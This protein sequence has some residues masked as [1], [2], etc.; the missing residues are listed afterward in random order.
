MPAT[1]STL[2]FSLYLAPEGAEITEIC[3]ADNLVYTNLE[4][5]QIVTATG[6]YT[7]PEFPLGGF[8]TYAW[9]ETLISDKGNV[10]HEGACGIT[11]ELT[12]VEVPD[13]TTLA[14]PL[15]TVVDPIFDT[16]VVN[17]S[18]PDNT[19]LEFELY[20]KP[21]APEAGD[22]KYDADGNVTDVAW[23]QEEV[24]AQSDEAVC[25]VSNLVATTSRIAVTAGSNDYVE[26]VS[27]DVNVSETGTYWWVERLIVE[28]PSGD[29]VVLTGECGL[30][31]ETTEVSDPVVTSNA[32]GSVELGEEAH[33]VATVIGPI[34]GENSGVRAELT[35]EAFEAVEAVESTDATDSTEPAEVCAVDNR[36][37]NLDE[38]IIVT[39]A[40][41]YASSSV[42]FPKTGTYYWVETLAYVNIATDE[43]T[44]V[45]VG[46][47]GL[48]EETTIVTAVPVV[49]GT[50]AFT[51][52][53]SIATLLVSGSVALLI[54]GI[55]LSFLAWRNR[56]RKATTTT[57][58]TAP[59]GILEA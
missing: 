44:V 50:L 13:V 55:G 8:G 20:K 41:D 43:R 51:G 57:T 39:A 30:A 17:G 49:P 48:P 4:D 18:V 10:I 24:D 15:A 38:P 53:S 25:D 40:G 56:R 32:V 23:T 36:V 45:H 9:V 47:C 42:V 28:T 31:T 34:P 12:T 1:P 19:V 16:A 11:N 14:M 29:V 52:S 35:F 3:T 58:T 46:E 33:D 2:A 54:L 26:Y 7:S 37:F 5:G 22:F 6:E 27:P 21:T 59:V